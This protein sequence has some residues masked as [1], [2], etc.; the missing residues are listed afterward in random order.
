M[1]KRFSAQAEVPPA[2]RVTASADAMTIR[3]RRLLLG[4]GGRG[5]GGGV[6][7]VAV[8]GSMIRF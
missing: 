7:G 8:S 2:T 3:R 6:G 5:G 4:D 1:T